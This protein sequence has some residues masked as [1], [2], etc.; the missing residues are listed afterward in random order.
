MSLRDLTDKT[1]ILEA[2]AEFD[3]L[4]RDAFLEKY[5]FG[6]SKKYILDYKGRAFDSKAI[7]GAAHGFQFPEKGPLDPAEFVGG[8]AT[9]LPKL[10]LLGFSV[11][12]LTEYGPL[13][14][15][16]M[17]PVVLVENEVTVGGKY[18]SW[19][20]VT[21]ETYHFPN[22]YRNLVV[23]GTPFIYYR[24]SRRKGGGRGEPE[25]FGC[26]YVGEVLLDPE[27][28][29]DAPR[30]NWKWFAE[31]E[32]FVPF[33][34]PV[35]AKL[36]GRFFEPIPRNLWSMGVRRISQEAYESILVHGQVDQVVAAEPGTLL[37]DAPRSDTAKVVP[38]ERGRTL[39]VGVK[40]A[41]AQ[42]AAGR[43]RRYSAFSKAIGDWAE[44][45]VFNYLSSTLRGAARDTLR[46]VSKERIT[47]GWDIQYCVRDDQL[48]A[49]EVKGTRGPMFPSVELTQN[50]WQ[51]A[52]EKRS[53]YGLY[54]LA[55]CCSDAPRLEQLLDPV[56]RTEAGELVASPT[57]WQLR[58]D[59][60]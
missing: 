16:P 13:A 19:K 6:R 33:P 10:R 5:G 34:H 32:G 26:G 18:D 38:V 44:G 14:R 17:P 37:R 1:A 25:Y 43:P 55:N 42:A 9:V 8:E 59:A 30:K 39:L 50:E 48:V 56:G 23:S 35:P 11:R 21:G 45:A 57:G 54:L 40:R 49:V 2:I 3:R 12:Q 52:R 41:A 28:R 36:G 15:G 27:V 4:G 22:N 31:I 29:P 60:S 58:R 20:D 46:W 53:D 7:V 51:A 24:G 47:P